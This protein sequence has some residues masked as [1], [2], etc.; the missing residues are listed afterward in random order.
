MSD[1]T[2]ENNPSETRLDDATA[3]SV[4][5]HI[6]GVI[7]RWDM[8]TDNISWSS[9]AA[10]TLG[11]ADEKL[12]VKGRAFNRI[13]LPTSENSRPNVIHS[14]E[15]SDEGQ[16]VA[17]SLQYAISAENASA[18]KDVWIE[19]SGRWFAGPNGEP[20]SAEGVMRV[21][22]DRRN[23]Q[24]DLDYMARFDPLTGLHNRSHLNYSLEKTFQT[25]RDNGGS[26]GFLLIGIDHFD[27]IN[28]VY[29]YEAGDAVISEVARRL[30][31]HLR[32]SDVL[33]R[34]SGARIGIV[35]NDCDERNMLVAGYRIL[36]VL[37][38][39]VVETDAGPIAISASVGGVLIPQHA[40][41]PKRTFSAAYNALLESRREHE[42]TIVSYR[43]DPQAER[44]HREAV[45]LS[46]KII[47]A[48]KQ[49][50]IHL[51]F[52]PIVDATTHE[53][54]FFEAL[55]RLQDDDG[56]VLA[57]GD[58]VSV[59]IRLGLIRLVDHQALDLAIEALDEH[60]SAK[61]SL[62]VSNETATD[63]E[64]ISKLAIAALRRPDITDRLIIEITE[65]HVAESLEE[66][67]R[68][69]ASLHDLGFKVAIDDFGAGFTSFRNLKALNYDIIKIDGEFARDLKD[70]PENQAFIK[71]LI[72]LAH[73]FDARTVVEWVEDTTTANHLRDWGVDLLQGFRFSKPLRQPKWPSEETFEDAPAIPIAAIA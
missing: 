9:G 32:D 23:L 3:A 68:F 64:W 27:L 12:P 53:V 2:I 25:L 66:A 30:R 52:Q 45:K 49:G 44:R 4:L 13:L 34:F 55:V 35:L 22:T 15:K 6:G 71:S 42:A 72:G 5:G 51:A 47:M 59:A 57:A 29:G 65:S 62:N 50:R 19:D 60:E 20:A 43:P 26:A 11:L 8:L 28:T 14:S 24:D 38:G 37:R 31:L 33:G 21:I 69:I 40:S 17:Y 36:N 73:Q 18:Q 7:Y 70:N 16:G 58:F 56:H 48:L 1:Y 41:N 39:N 10:K 63:P 67:R 54:E 61:I 46:E